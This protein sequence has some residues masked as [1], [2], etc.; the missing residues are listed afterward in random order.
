ML[1]IEDYTD[2]S[3]APLDK[4]YKLRDVATDNCIEQKREYQEAQER[5]VEIQMEIANRKAQVSSL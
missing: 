4:L 2:L 3:K 5:L 1:V